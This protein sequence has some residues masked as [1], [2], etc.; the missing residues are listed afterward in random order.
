MVQVRCL[1]RHLDDED[2]FHER[3]DELLDEFAAWLESSQLTGGEPGY[4]GVAMDCRSG[5]GLEVGLPGRNL[6]RWTVPDLDEFLLGWC[7][8]KLS[9]PTRG[10]TRSC[11]ARLAPS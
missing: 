10:F 8:R 11:F 1:P 2:A 9:G 5:D 7:P 4:A 6:S 3:R